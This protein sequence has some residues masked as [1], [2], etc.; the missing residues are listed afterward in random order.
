MIKIKIFGIGLS[1]TGTV[2]L[3]EALKILGYDIKHYPKPPLIPRLIKVIEKCDGGTDTPIAVAYKKLD[4]AFPGSKFILTT[5]SYRTWIKSCKNY[6][7][8]RVPLQG[9]TKRLRMKLYNHNGFNEEKFKTAYVKHHI[10][11]AEYFNKRKDLLVMNLD[12]GDFNWEKLCHFLG[13]EI[14]DVPFPHKN[15]TKIIEKKR[16]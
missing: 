13:K 7:H 6:R 1:R 9:A 12:K 14:P 3:T 11:V 2:S 16:K 8:F 5:R 15:K 4:E 10:R